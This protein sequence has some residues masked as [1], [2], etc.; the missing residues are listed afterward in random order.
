MAKDGRTAK[1]PSPRSP[2][3]HTLHDSIQGG[4]LAAGLRMHASKQVKLTTEISYNYQVR[5]SGSK[6]GQCNL[7]HGS[8]CTLGS[9]VQKFGVS[10]FNSTHCQRPGRTLALI[11]VTLHGI[12]IEFSVGDRFSS[13]S[14]RLGEPD[15]SSG[16]TPKKPHQQP[17][18]GHGACAIR[19]QGRRGMSSP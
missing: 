8:Y 16:R 4:S 17:I 2:S 3:N 5:K 15:T 19:E 7:G 11:L 12:S 14:Q 1:I 6:A 13:A 18:W 10:S 9:A